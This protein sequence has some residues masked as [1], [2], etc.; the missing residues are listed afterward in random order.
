[1]VLHWLF[2]TKKGSGYKELTEEAE[3]H[4]V[5]QCTLVHQF[6]FSISTLRP[7]TESLVLT[8]V[9]YSLPI[10]SKIHKGEGFSR[11]II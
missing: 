9:L 5:L 8:L 11:L 7:L 6:I 3:L 1:M 2:T 4:G 10:V